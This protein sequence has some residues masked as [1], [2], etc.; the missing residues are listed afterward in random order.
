MVSNRVVAIR[1]GRDLKNLSCICEVKRD[2]QQQYG[3]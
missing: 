3:A 1:N 2:F